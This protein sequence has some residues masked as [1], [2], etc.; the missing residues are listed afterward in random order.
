MYDHDLKSNDG[1]YA[2]AQAIPQTTTGEDVVGNGGGLLLSGTMGGIE[3]K[4]VVNTEFSVSDGKS[5]SIKL[6]D[7]AGGTSY[8]AKGTLYSLTA[9]G[10]ES[11][12]AG[13]V[14]GV[15][16]LPSDTE[17]YTRVV[18]TST[19]DDVDGKVDVYATYNPR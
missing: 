3:V 8:A 4:A 16:T 11:V 6:Q 7:S 10:T 19:D 2:K 15:Y 9:D 17:K 5:I 1:Y 18:L 14:L 12:A 13:T